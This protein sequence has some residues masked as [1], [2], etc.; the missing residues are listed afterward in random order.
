M[1]VPPIVCDHLHMLF[2]EQNLH[3]DYCSHKPNGLFQ[4]DYTEEKLFQALFAGV[5]TYIS[6]Q[7]L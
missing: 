6:S 1:K 3:Y 2:P 5:F 7:I 4:R